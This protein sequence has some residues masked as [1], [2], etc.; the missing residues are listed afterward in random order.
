MFVGGTSLSQNVVGSTPALLDQNDV[1]DDQWVAIADKELCPA[2][3]WAQI[4]CWGGD[5]TT[6]GICSPCWEMIWGVLR[7]EQLNNLPNLQIGVSE[8]R[9]LL[10][11]VD[12]YRASGQGSPNQPK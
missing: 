7:G 1:T 10:P 2:N 4:G 11:N 5:S 6:Y 9:S 12:I 8:A 3:R